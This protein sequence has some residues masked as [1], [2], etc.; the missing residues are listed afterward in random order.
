MNRLPRSILARQD[1]RL[2]IQGG[3]ALLLFILITQFMSAFWGCVAVLA[4]IGLIAFSFPAIAPPFSSWMRTAQTHIRKMGA[5]GR[6][7]A[8]AHEEEADSAVPVSPE[9]DTQQAIRRLMRELDALADGDLT[10]RATV[11]ENITGVIADLINYTIEELALL[12]RHIHAIAGQLRQATS[13][14]QSAA[15]NLL[16]AAG[17]Q[18]AQVRGSVQALNQASET[19]QTA[20]VV[21]A[22]AAQAAQTAQA[23]A[24]RGAEAVKN[25]I[26]GMTELRRH[27]QQ[28]AHH[29]KRLGESSQETSEIVELIAQLAGQVNDLAIN[30]GMQ[31]ANGQG[32]AMVAAD[33]QE[34][35]NRARQAGQRISAIA[36]I[37]QN[38]A[39]DAMAAMDA[40][41]TQVIRSSELAHSAGEALTE[42]DQTSRDTLAIIGALSNSM[43][44]RASHTQQAAREMNGT[45]PL[46]VQT[47]DRARETTAALETLSRLALE[48]NTATARFRL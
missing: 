13:I 6:R 2:A 4:V 21:G 37:A 41:T 3:C 16:Q 17:Q 36:D 44:A 35:A 27:I 7:E 26:T 20:T 40:A 48:L 23:A 29:L 1:I 31:A 45:L 39:R 47:T 9:A 38:N 22:R 11:T 15:S 10:V 34:L 12:V 32:A 8:E 42:I 19:M 46:L 28:S 43:R 24:L 25:S 5:N 14:T 18:G 33:I 30:A